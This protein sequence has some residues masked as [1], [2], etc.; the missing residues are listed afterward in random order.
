MA[1]TDWLHATCTGYLLRI[2]VSP[3]AARHQVV[4]QLGDRLKIRIAAPP[5]KGAANEAL[6][7]FLA[8]RLGIGKPRL[9]LRSGAGER[10]KLVEID[11][12][13]PELRSRLLELAAGD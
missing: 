13:E 4:G 9:R 1:L 7:D 2:Q 12:L 6:L 5:V 11:G 8:R 10:L 3:G